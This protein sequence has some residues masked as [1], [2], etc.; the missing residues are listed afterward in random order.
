VESKGRQC[1]EKLKRK[2]QKER[3]RD[4]GG[5][6]R[7]SAVQASAYRRGE[8]GGKKSRKETGNEGEKKGEKKK[9]IEERRSRSGDRLPRAKIWERKRRGQVV[10]GIIKGNKMMQGGERK[11]TQKSQAFPRG[12]RRTDTVVG[13][14][15][16]K[17]EKGGEE[18]SG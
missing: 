4:R 12:V 8:M 14:T 16:G 11:K 17:K 7:K 1:G 13:D 18:R 5:K 9:R 2:I 6:N 10:A 3:N 15:L